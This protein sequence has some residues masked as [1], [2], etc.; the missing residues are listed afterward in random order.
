MA[1]P[2]PNASYAGGFSPGADLFAVD[3]DFTFA[4]P[5]GPPI[6]SN[7][8]RGDSSVGTN[9][10][11]L[12]DGTGAYVRIPIGSGYNIQPF[13]ANQS[14]ILFEQEFIV[15]QAYFVPMPLNTPY[16]LIW[17]IGWQNT[18]VALD[19]CFL[20]EESPLEPIG[21]GLARLR[22]RFANLPPNRNEFESFTYVYPAV[23]YGG[24]DIRLQKPLTVNSR[25]QND[26]FVFDDLGLLPGIPLF[27]AGHRLDSTTGTNP[28]GLILPQMRFFKATANAAGNNNLLDA[29][30][31]LSDGP[32]PTVPSYTEY[33][34]FANWGGTGTVAEIVAEASSLQRWQG[35]IYERKT[36]FVE[37]V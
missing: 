14:A 3:G 25:V 18:Y 17:S 26:Y 35:N 2:I 11:V 34:G 7:S 29:D 22:R 4:E 21:G 13:A 19:S 16:P 20:V 28:V 8:F 10:I 33:A 24:S 12:L 36:R 32:P 1:N 15:A 31:P 27:P 9:D 5:F 23:D 6:V 37:A 30:Q